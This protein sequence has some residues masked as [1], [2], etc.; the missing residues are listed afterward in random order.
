MDNMTGFDNQ[1]EPPQDA[2]GHSRIG[3]DVQKREDR[4]QDQGIGHAAIGD[5]EIMFRTKQIPNNKQD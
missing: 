1:C 5:L 4:E 2:Q 3:N